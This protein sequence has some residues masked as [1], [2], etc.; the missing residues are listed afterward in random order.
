MSSGVAIA[1]RLDLTTSGV[2]ETALDV[3]SCKRGSV[4]APLGSQLALPPYISSSRRIF[5]EAGPEDTKGTIE[6]L[7]ARYSFTV[8]YRL[9]HRFTKSFIAWVIILTYS[10]SISF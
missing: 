6:V 7:Y 9:L 2:L 8:T 3:S 1:N 10:E 4:E 5:E